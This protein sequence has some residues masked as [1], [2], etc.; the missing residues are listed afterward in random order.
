MVSNRIIYK[1]NEFDGNPFD[2][3]LQA[4][5][6]FLRASI[7]MITRYRTN[8]GSITKDEIMFAELISRINDE[9]LILDSLDKEEV[10][11]LREESLIYKH[12]KFNDVNDFL[13]K[14]NNMIPTSWSHCVPRMTDEVEKII[15]S[16]ED[17]QE[18][19]KLYEVADQLLDKCGHD[20][21]KAENLLMN[22]ISLID[23]SEDPIPSEMDTSDSYDDTFV[24]I[25]NFITKNDIRTI[26]EVEL[27]L[28]H[29]V[30]KRYEHETGMNRMF[31]ALKIP[32]NRRV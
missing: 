23:D 13:F 16:D 6:E 25:K 3:I 9:L 14:F 20:Y 32:E 10:D 27:M 8:I 21:N 15:L 11:K 18:R 29:I 30:I 4:S 19:H 2:V 22:V 31:D 1:D 5:I 17:L 12:C 28:S 24:S 26:E 7:F